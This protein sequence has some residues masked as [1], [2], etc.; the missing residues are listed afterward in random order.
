VLFV[1]LDAWHCWYKHLVVIQVSRFCTAC[2]QIAYTSTPAQQLQH[3]EAQHITI[4][5]ALAVTLA[6][7]CVQE[8]RQSARAEKLAEIRSGKAKSSKTAEQKE[9]GKKFAAQMRADS[10]YQGED[11]EVFAKWLAQGHGEPK[12]NL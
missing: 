9:T 5:H 10:D 2:M 4:T 7:A 11:Y 6:R 1:R 8:G 12:T 3:P